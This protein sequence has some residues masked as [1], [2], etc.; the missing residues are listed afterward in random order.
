[1]VTADELGIIMRDLPCPLKLSTSGPKSDRHGQIG[2]WD[3]LGVRRWFRFESV[4]DLAVPSQGC[5]ELS[6]ELSAVQVCRLRIHLA[7]SPKKK[8]K[9][10]NERVQLG[11]PRRNWQEIENGTG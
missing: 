4:T 11:R 7:T 5:C 10:T 1:M 3:R 2:R 8:K 9:S 6:R